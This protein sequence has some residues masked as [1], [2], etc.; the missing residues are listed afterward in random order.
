VLADDAH[1]QVEGGDLHS[2]LGGID[3]DVGE[4]GHGG[5]AF[6]DALGAIERP[7]QL[8]RGNAEFHTGVVPG[9]SIGS[10]PPLRLGD[11]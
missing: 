8:V 10:S 3:Q 11:V 6:H 9:R 5:L 2:G 7:F 4:D 1:V